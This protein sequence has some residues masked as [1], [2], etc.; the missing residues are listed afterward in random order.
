VSAVS[1]GTAPLSDMFGVA[2]E[3]TAIK[4]LHDALDAGISFFDSSPYY[5]GRLAERRLAGVSGLE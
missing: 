5:C 2:D 1:F 4:T 3:T